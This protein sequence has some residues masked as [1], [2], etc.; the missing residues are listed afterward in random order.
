MKRLLKIISVS[1]ICLVLGIG[2]FTVDAADNGTVLY[3]N[4]FSSGVD[5]TMN[6][7]AAGSYE[8]TT[9]FGE[10]FLRCKPLVDGTKAF[11]IN[12][13][14]EEA[15]NVDISFRIRS[16]SAQSNSS[17]F[18]GLYFRCPSLPA[19]FKFAYQLRL[20]S[21]KTSLV[22]MDD[23]ADTVQTVLTEEATTTF[24]DYLW[25]N[26]KVCL[27]ETRIVVFVNGNKVMDLDND[28]YLPL[29]GFGLCSSRYTFDVDDIKIIGYKGKLPEPMPNEAPVWVGD[30]F[31]NYKADIPDSGKERLNLLNLGGEKGSGTTKISVVNPNELTI[32]SWIAIGLIAALVVM[33]LSTLLVSFKLIKIIKDNKAENIG[34]TSDSGTKGAE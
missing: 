33:A 10:T 22:L 28:Y 21:K 34:D 11:R 19:N 15:K 17:A 25:Y 9:M 24:T 7:N 26:V 3:H 16:T 29:G 14:P 6:Y 23:Y 27:R 18:Y 8:V 1:I 5:S 4:D 32:N 20:S 13:G 2:I 12:F 31:G 30:P